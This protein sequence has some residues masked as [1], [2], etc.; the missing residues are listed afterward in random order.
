MTV[1]AR[2]VCLIHVDERD[3]DRLRSLHDTAMR[4]GPL[5]LLDVAA[6]GRVVDLL[7]RAFDPIEEATEGR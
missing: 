5:Q 3:L 7:E 2:G 1:R 4:S 6:L